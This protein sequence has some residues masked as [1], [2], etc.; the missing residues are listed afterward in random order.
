VATMDWFWRA[1]KGRCEPGT[2]VPGFVFAVL[3]LL[4]HFS[5]QTE[6]PGLHNSLELMSRRKF[7]PHPESRDAFI[8][9]LILLLI[10]T[11]ENRV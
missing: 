5:A 6:R 9:T 11:C 8:L 1:L 7:T 3:S 10:N 4:Q 2:S